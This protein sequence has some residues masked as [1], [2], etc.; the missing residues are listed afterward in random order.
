MTSIDTVTA[1]DAAIEIVD[2]MSSDDLQGYTRENWTD[3][4]SAMLKGTWEHLDD[5]EVL[6][7]VGQLVADRRWKALTEEAIELGLITTATEIIIAKNGAGGVI[8]AIRR[9]ASDV[10]LAENGDVI[11]WDQLGG[12]TVASVLAARN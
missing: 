8:D 12:I 2:N 4:I 7:E 5:N 3:G 6:D 1:Q 10:W 11:G 9:D